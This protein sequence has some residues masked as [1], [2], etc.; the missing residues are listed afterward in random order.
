MSFLAGRS[1]AIEGAYFLQESKQAVNRLANKLKPKFDSSPLPPSPSSI[2]SSKSFE[3]IGVEN[4]VETADVLPEILKHKLPPNIYLSSSAPV[5]NSSHSRFHASKWVVQTDPKKNTTSVSVDALNP[6]RGYVSLPQVTLGPRR[7]QLP[8]AESS[9]LASTANELRRDKYSH[10][11]PEKLEAAAAGLSQIGKAFVCATILVFGGA[12]LTFEFVAS[13]LE[14]HN[15]NDLQ[16]KGKD[17]VRPRFEKVR[18]QLNPLRT[19]AGDTA[20]KWHL[21]KEDTF[22]ENPLIKE[23]SRTLG[24]KSSN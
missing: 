13:K 22:K 2:N 8:N 14:L 3:K 12:I 21:E 24:A 1:A 15:S 6:L 20:K 19:W 4:Q 16:T 17:F 7:W 18:E 5:A 10:V 9:V 23:L 11:N